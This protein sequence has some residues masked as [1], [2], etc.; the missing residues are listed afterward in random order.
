[1]GLSPHIDEGSE[2]EAWSSRLRLDKRCCCYSLKMMSTQNKANNSV[3]IN[4]KPMK[5]D[6]HNAPSQ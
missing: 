2:R 6:F 1:M 5:T 4:D 3:D